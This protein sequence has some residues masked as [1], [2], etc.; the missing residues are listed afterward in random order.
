MQEKRKPPV[1]SNAFLEPKHVN[2]CLKVGAPTRCEDTAQAEP[3]A[4]VVHLR[5]VLG[6]T[7]ALT[8]PHPASAYLLEPRAIAMV[9]L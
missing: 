4:D 3:A 2:S 6:L 1:E 5:C 7:N 8:I 9:I